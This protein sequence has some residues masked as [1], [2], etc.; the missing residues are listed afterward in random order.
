MSIDAP[1][2][3]VCESRSSAPYGMVNEFQIWQCAVC[4]CLYVHPMPDDALLHAIYDRMEW[5]NGEALDNNIPVGYD[6]YEEQTPMEYPWTRPFAE[7]MELFSARRPS[8]PRI[9]DIGCAYG[10][11]LAYFN[12]RGWEAVGVEYSSHAR[13][14][15]AKRPDAELSVFASVE[16]VP[17]GEPFDAVLILET[18]EHLVDPYALFK[19][20][21]DYGLIDR[22]TRIVLTTPNAAAE[23]ARAAGEKWQYL[24]PPT[25]VILF[26]PESMGELLSR[27]GFKATRIGGQYAAPSRLVKDAYPDGVFQISEY[28][29]LLGFASGFDDGKHQAGK[30]TAAWDAAREEFIFEHCITKTNFHFFIDVA[31]EQLTSLERHFTEKKKRTWRLWR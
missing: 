8:R 25:H 7:A 15:A 5:F 31:R 1:N 9:L 24:H 21:G 17:R 19:R 30:E 6:D 3:P 11:H 22:H 14:M 27:A 10:K 2:C 29:G 13:E 26:T 16:D 4:R 20:L 18:I 12:T 28:A 23:G